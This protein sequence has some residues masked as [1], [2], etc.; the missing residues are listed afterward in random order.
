MRTL[1]IAERRARLARRHHL[2]TETRARQVESA[3]AGMLCLHATDPAT[4]YLS[5]WA[6]VE[7]LSVADV[8]KALYVDRSLVKHLAM[9]RTLFDF[10]R[11]ILPVAQAGASARVADAESRR[12]VR[13]VEKA[14]LFEN[15][16]LWLERASAAV[17]AELVDGREAT[18]SELRTSIPL[19]EGTMTYGA[20]KAWVAT[21]RS[22]LACSRRCP[23]RAGSCAHPTTADGPYRGPAGPPSTHGW[24]ARSTL[25]T[26]P[27]PERLW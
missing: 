6:R 14:G 3:T 9:R 26:R 23:P 15:G 20:G 17:L 13:D 22:D 24:A 21:P 8:D 19:L 1:D 4:V 25:S 16:E 12:L 18:S 27:E 7:K 5:A 2:A 11:E 10:L